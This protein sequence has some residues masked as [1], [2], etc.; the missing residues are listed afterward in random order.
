MG[1]FLRGFTGVLAVGVF[2][3]GG[4]FCDVRAVWWL[5]LRSW[6]AIVA[7][8]GVGFGV[9]ECELLD[10]LD[11]VDFVAERSS[12]ICDFFTKRPFLSSHTKYDFPL[13]LPLFLPTAIS[14]STPYHVPRS[15][16]CF[17]YKSNSALLG[18]YLHV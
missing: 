15:K 11:P 4:F 13:T 14:S 18:A 17:S 7:C 5:V 16:L 6:E 9:F 2:V 12:R 1:R 10:A 3:V 8:L